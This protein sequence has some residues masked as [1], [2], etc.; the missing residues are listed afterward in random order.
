MNTSGS[1]NHRGTPR[2]AAEREQRFGLLARADRQV[3]ERINALR[4]ALGKVTGWLPV[5]EPV[6]VPVPV[7]PERG[8]PARR[9]G[10]LALEEI[11]GESMADIDRRLQGRINAMRACLGK[12]PDWQPAS[13]PGNSAAELVLSRRRC[14]I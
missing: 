2:V 8:I 10:R 9:G 1:D 11:D 7:G 4:G 6:P 13:G 3:T 5:P 12:T 14:G